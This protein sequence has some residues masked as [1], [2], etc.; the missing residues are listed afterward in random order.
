MVRDPRINTARHDEGLNFGRIRIRQSFKPAVVA[1]QC[2]TARSK[3]GD[4]WIPRI[5]LGTRAEELDSCPVV[6]RWAPWTAVDSFFCDFVSEQASGGHATTAAAATARAGVV[7][8]VP[9]LSAFFLTRIQSIVSGMLPPPARRLQYM[10]G[11]HIYP[12]LFWDKQCTKRPMVGSR[13]R[14]DGVVAFHTHM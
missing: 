4:I 5:L 8:H 14:G 6:E 1:Q 7:N 3:G 13:R 10:H 2:W 11:G 12:R 9:R